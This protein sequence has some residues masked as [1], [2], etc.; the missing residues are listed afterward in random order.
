LANRTYYIQVGALTGDTGNV[1][2]NFV[3]GGG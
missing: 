2:L 3:K 1:I